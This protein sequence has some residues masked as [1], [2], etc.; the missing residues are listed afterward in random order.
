MTDG[1][2]HATYRLPRYDTK[3]YDIIRYDITF[4]RHDML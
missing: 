4:L 2:A 3:L 1:E